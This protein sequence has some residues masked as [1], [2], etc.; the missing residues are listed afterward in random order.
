VSTQQDKEAVEICRRLDVDAQH[1][2]EVA[3]HERRLFDAGICGDRIV[4]LGA[5]V[6]L[7]EAAV[8]ERLD[9]PAEHLGVDVGVHADGCFIEQPRYPCTGRIR[10]EAD[11]GREHTE[12][13]PSVVELTA[14]RRRLDSARRAVLHAAR[15]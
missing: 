1:V 2:V 8:D 14:S 4:E 12:A 13:H 6:G 11:A 15:R 5:F 7:A 3:G 10:A 9:R